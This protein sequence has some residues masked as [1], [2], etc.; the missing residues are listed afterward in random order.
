MTNLDILR[1]AAEAGNIED[2][3]AVIENHPTILTDIDS[4]Q[5][6]ETP[7]H[8]AAMK[9]HL[10]FAMEVM[11]LKPSLAFKLNKQGFS[12]IH[13]AMQEKRKTMV[14]CFVDMNKD[15][16]KVKGKEGLTPLH[17]ASQIGE[18][19]LLAYFLKACPESIENL[20]VRCETALHIAINNAQFDALKVLVGWLERNYRTGAI[21]L[22][23]KI[24][25]Q[26]DEA[27]NTVLHISA[28]RSDQHEVII[29]LLEEF[30]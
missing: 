4:K 15:L 8:I 28:S 12:P 22:E 30:K 3:Y 25:N 27:G 2:L 13:L 7:L 5:F 16:V 11:N 26:K 20:T 9:G 18:I 1:P 17:Y 6:A 21:E 29:F 23:N 24:L 14:L 10:P 19:D